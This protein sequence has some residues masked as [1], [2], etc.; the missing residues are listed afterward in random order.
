M[1]QQP[2]ESHSPSW[3]IPSTMVWLPALIPFAHAVDVVRRARHRLL[4]AGDDALRVARLDRLGG[5]HHGLEA[6]AADLVDGEGGDGRRQS[7]VDQRL[8]GRGLAAAALHHL[9][10]DDLVDRAGVDAGPRDRLADDHGAELG[11]GK[12]GRDRRD[13][14]RSA[15]GRR[16]G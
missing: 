10:H 9:A 1:W 4:A 7:G 3:I 15:C 2:N 8:A 16:R 5:E 14:G 13:S 11:R 6:G 12:A